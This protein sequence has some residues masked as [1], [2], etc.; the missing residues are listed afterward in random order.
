MSAVQNNQRVAQKSLLP[1]IRFTKS[2]RKAENC[3]NA[4]VLAAPQRRRSIAERA[5]DSPQLD[6]FTLASRRR[7]SK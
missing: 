4:R 3:S 1:G 2:E 7:C 5:L 6:F